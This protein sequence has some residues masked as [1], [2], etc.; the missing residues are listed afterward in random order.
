MYL[1]KANKT[2]VSGQISFA[3][4]GD[5]VIWTPATPIIVIRWGFILDAAFTTT[6][7]ITQLDQR[8]TAGSDSNRVAGATSSGFDTAGGSFTASSTTLAAGKGNYHNVI[9]A[10]G[11]TETGSPPADAGESKSGW[12]DRFVVYPGQQLVFKVATASSSGTGFAFI[13][14]QELP[15][16]D[17]SKVST[18]D[19]TLNALAKM[20]KV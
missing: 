2:E 20:T 11:I 10:H 9:P 4:T 12:P 6:A 13:E 17:Q 18:S 8:V 16:Q 19:L 1:L 5:K 14:Y 3:S 15:F 7:A